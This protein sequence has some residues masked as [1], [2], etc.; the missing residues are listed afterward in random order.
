MSQIGGLT[1][2]EKN[3]EMGSYTYTSFRH[4]PGLFAQF[5]V[6]RFHDASLACVV[7]S[8]VTLSAAPNQ[9]AVC[10]MTRQRQRY[11]YDGCAVTEN[12]EERLDEPTGQIDRG[13]SLSFL[14]GQSGNGLS[15]V[16]YFLY[17]STTCE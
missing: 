14:N 6:L 13:L 8:S 12:R 2:H 16:E 7:A 3:H 5:M 11:L 10:T 17:L 1:K 15:R 4:I 9:N